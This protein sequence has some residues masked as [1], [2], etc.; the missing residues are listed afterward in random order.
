MQVR[1]VCAML[2]A[3]GEKRGERKVGTPR[4]KSVESG[5]GVCGNKTSVAVVVEVE[6][7]DC[8]LCVVVG[9][10]CGRLQWW[11]T[12]DS[13]SETFARVVKRVV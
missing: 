5:K 8:L 1:G 11:C 7:G 13:C 9:V 2:C 4:W 12:H 10:R 6:W 3:V